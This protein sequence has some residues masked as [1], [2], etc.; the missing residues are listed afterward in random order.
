MKNF[1]KFL[2]FVLC[3]V[4]VLQPLP[5]NAAGNNQGDSVEAFVSR[6]Y[7]VVLGREADSDGL[8]HWTSGLRS[9]SFNA[10]DIVRGFFW[11]TEYCQKSKTND[12][13]VI[14]CYNAMLG[15]NPD[16]EGFNH[17]V[18]RLNVGM[19]RDAIYAGFVGSTEFHNLCDSY[20]INPGTYSVTQECDK[21]YEVTSF[22]SRLYLKAL[23][24]DYDFDG[25]NNWCGE[26][27]SKQDRETVRN[28]ASNGFFHSQEFTDKNLD[29]GEYVKVLYRTFVGRE[30]DEPGY[31]YWLAKLNAGESRDSI[32]DGF[33]NSPEF[34]GMIGGFPE[35]KSDKILFIGDS[36]TVCCLKSDGG[37]VHNEVHDGVTVYAAWGLGYDFM[38]SSIAEYGDDYGTLAVWLGC[39]D[40][41]KGKSFYDDYA[42]F[43]EELLAQ[44]KKI[45][46]FNV[47]R[48]DDDCLA[49]GDEGYCDYN[50][51]E[52]N[53]TMSSWAQNRAGV[54]YV[55]VYSMSQNWLL[56][57]EDGIHY[58]PRPTQD[59][60]NTLI[61]YCR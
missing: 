40:A 16:D 14:D 39:N 8:N 15:R 29:N 59:I 45:I 42:G 4:V 28:V 17:W 25:L 10:I 18:T 27:N 24:R 30:Y 23:G 7:Q 19:T 48:T 21:S 37:T 41:A 2:A 49:P 47:G 9:G 13:L 44:G 43:Y 33:A 60:W 36:R 46:L 52:Y 6:M 51:V 57:D 12:E 5:V 35:R 34:N 1:T 11:S 50:M 22:V 31:N 20:G 53:K 61:G 32:L 26:I 58:W 38:R 56:N 55:D 54:T 3:L